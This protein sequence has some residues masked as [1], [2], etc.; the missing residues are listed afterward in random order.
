MDTFPLNPMGFVS[1]SNG[2][3]P[4]ILCVR[5]EYYTRKKIRKSV[6]V[7]WNRL[8]LE[9][10]LVATGEMNPAKDSDSPGRRHFTTP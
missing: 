10:R 6:T 3:H 7:S 2:D 5:R 1:L 9:G 4:I 8:E